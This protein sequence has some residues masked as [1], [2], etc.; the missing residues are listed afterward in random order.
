MPFL[1]TPTFMKFKYIPL[2]AA[3]IGL[4]LT[5]GTSSCGSDAHA[6]DH[7]HDHAIDTGSVVNTSSTIPVLKDR[8]DG[9]G[10]LE[11]R[12]FSLDAYDKAKYTAIADPNNGNAWLELAQVFMQEAR[13]TGDFGYNYDAALSMLDKILESE[14]YNK[15]IVFQALTLKGS[16]KLSEHKFQEALELGENASV[17]NPY[18]ALV[19]G[20]MI[21]ANVELGNYA[22]AVELSDKMVSIRPDLRSYSRISYLRE[23][24]GDLP[25]AIEAME[26]AI[27]A[28]YPGFE[29][30]AWCQVILARLH[31]EQGELDKAEGTI[32]TALAERPNYPY[33]LAELGVIEHKKGNIELAETWLLQA[34]ALMNNPGFQE[35]LVQIY[36]QKN[37][38]DLVKLHTERALAFYGVPTEHDH[39]HASEGHHHNEE[40]AHSH[41]EEHGHSHITGLEI[42]R[43]RSEFSEDYDEA[44]DNAMDDYK[45]RPENIEVNLALATIYYQ[46]QDH[47]AAQMHL[48]K[49]AATGSI[50]SHLLTMKGLLSLA[51]G[52]SAEGKRELKESFERN[53]YQVGRMADLAKQKLGA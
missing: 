45:E 13:I 53:P 7:N 50:S 30:R 47:V 49:A 52:K 43:F 27:T 23:I 9:L 11:E 8:P 12:D 16:I 4:S 1:L 19:Y 25:G 24:H 5:I 21:D 44:L 41:A 6:D 28:G 42:A 36:R 46:K 17:M 32:R 40:E 15:D 51:Q 14:Q 29:D 31:Q 38:S 26:M 37:A 10:S 3:A 48:E 39:D 22:K 2:L 34:E 33:A 35:H 20:I 18:N